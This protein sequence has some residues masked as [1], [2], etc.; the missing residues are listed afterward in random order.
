[1]YSTYTLLDVAQS[2]VEERNARAKR[3]HE[4]RQA[5]AHERAR[6]HFQ[7]SVRRCLRD[8]L[9]EAELA[10]QLRH[11]LHRTHRN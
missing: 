7:R 11:V 8:G 10:A 9:A 6:L 1:M 5:A 3:N 4:F 2:M